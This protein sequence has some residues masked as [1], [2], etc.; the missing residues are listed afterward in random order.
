MN[1]FRKEYC[2]ENGLNW[3]KPENTRAKDYVIWLEDKLKEAITVTRSC[4]QLNNK[5]VDT[6][7]VWI[8]KCGMKKVGNRIILKNNNQVSLGFMLEVYSNQVNKGYL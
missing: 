1:E 6:F 4:T 3:I 7:E 2:E 5:E 8:K